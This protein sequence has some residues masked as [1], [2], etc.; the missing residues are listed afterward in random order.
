MLLPG[1]AAADQFCRNM[2]MG[3]IHLLAKKGGW[4]GVPPCSINHGRGDVRGGG[5][6]LCILPCFP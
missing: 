5:V 2:Q 1:P 3:V 6:A 4:K